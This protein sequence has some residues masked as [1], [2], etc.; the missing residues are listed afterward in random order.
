ME[1]IR[2]KPACKD[3]LWGGT[4]LR[5]QYHISCKCQ[6]L[7][8]AWVLSCHKDGVSVVAS[9]NHAGTP[10][11]TYLKIMGKEI[12]GQNCQH[13]QDFPVLIKLIDAKENL[14]I[15]VH[16]TD[17]YAL[18][19]H[20]EYGKTE[21]WYIL[22]AEP[23]AFLYYGFNQNLSLQ[24][25]QQRILNNTLTD[26]LNKVSVSAGDVFFIPAGTVH[27]ICKGI[28][29]AEIQQN[30]NI[31]YRVYDYGRTDQKGNTRPLHIPQALE[32]SNTNICNQN[33]DFNHHLAQCDY[34]T[35]DLLQDECEGCCG[36]ESFA[37]FLV[38]EGE[39]TLCCNSEILSLKKG[40]SLFMPANSGHWQIHGNSK[41]LLTQVGI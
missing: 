9:G 41:V 33:W 32:V 11:P 24:E 20:Q 3:Y 29:L 13:F 37:H 14:S 6:P 22:Q 21:M 1:I 17:S 15:Q 35:T 26:V 19:H 23:E 38:V 2:L 8:E 36:L 5:E 39:G 7:A 31:T 18:Q 34:F 12:L 10:F 40:D 16:P 25:Y 4:K 30:S 27:A 28:V